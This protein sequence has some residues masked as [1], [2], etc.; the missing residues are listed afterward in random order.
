M[1]ISEVANL[2][3]ANLTK[4]L[5]T[6]EPYA[7][8]SERQIPLNRPAREAI[9]AYLRD[10]RDSDSPYLFVSKNGKPLAVR[11]IRASIDKYLRR[12][13]LSEYSVNDL[14]NTFIVESLKRGV[15]LVTISQAAGHRRLSTTERYLQISGI[16][17]PG[18]KQFLEEL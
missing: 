2:K 7:T 5:V 12:A 13:G 17:E 18:K 3:L 15:D 1:R 10:R 16:T 11:N 14:R 8:Q 6:I 4:D 9:E